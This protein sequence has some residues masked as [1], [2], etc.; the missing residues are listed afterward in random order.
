MIIKPVS[1][2][3][4]KSKK[5]VDHKRINTTAA[6][7]DNQER[8]N[9]QPPPPTVQQ[10]IQLIYELL[11]VAWRQILQYVDQKFKEFN[12]YQLFDAFGKLIAKHPFLALFFSGILLLL[13]LPFLIFSVFALA[14]AALTL[15]GF[16]VFEGTLITVASIILFG[17]IGCTLFVILFFGLV[18]IAGYFG[19]LKIYD[20]FETNT[21]TQKSAITSFLRQERLLP[22]P[23]QADNI[24]ISGLR[25]VT[26]IFL[27]IV[28]NVVLL[29]I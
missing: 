1:G 28:N 23:M 20:I 8:S 21:E 5:M 6:T 19:F 13:L 22:E 15:T 29:F 2:P 11:Q 9:K 4:I 26:I 14:T 18:I 7:S 25:S 24:W 27:E 10:L 3:E 12:V 17:F 16:V